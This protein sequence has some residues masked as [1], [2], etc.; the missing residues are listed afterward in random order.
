MDYSQLLNSII[1]ENI[2]RLNEWKPLSHRPSAM[3]EALIYFASP[4]W[5]CNKLVAPDDFI[6]GLVRAGRQ[7]G[8]FES[9]ETM[10]EFIQ[11][12]MEFYAP[13][14]NKQ[15]SD[16]IKESIGN[17][18]KLSIIIYHWLYTEPLSEIPDKPGLTPSE[19]FTKLPALS[20]LIVELNKLEKF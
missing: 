3:Y 14:V 17:H 18:V 1:N 2:G 13:Y 5:F 20:A 15:F 16:N 7:W 10:L 6:A 11:S 19:F 12:R 8:V 4:F 9:D